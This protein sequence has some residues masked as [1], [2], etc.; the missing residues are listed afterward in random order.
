[1]T[2][3]TY[4]TTPTLIEEDGTDTDWQQVPMTGYHMFPYSTSFLLGGDTWALEF[5]IIPGRYKDILNCSLLKQTAAGFIAIYDW[6]IKTGVEVVIDDT[7]RILGLYIISDLRDNYKTKK[8]YG[9]YN[10]AV[11]EV[12]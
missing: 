8:V 2:V 1:M 11:S 9:N 12:L 10:V 5:Y 6:S 7:I 3:I 4:N